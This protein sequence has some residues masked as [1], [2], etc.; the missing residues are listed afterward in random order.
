MTS[1]GQKASTPTVM[2]TRSSDAV[3][4]TIVTRD[5]TRADMYDPG[6]IL[7]PSKID[8][9][10]LARVQAMWACMSVGEGSGEESGED[11]S[12]E[13]TSWPGGGG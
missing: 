7:H 3:K 13:A 5:A 8:P 1:H 9:V 10:V 4:A 6:P 11:E 12:A 2:P